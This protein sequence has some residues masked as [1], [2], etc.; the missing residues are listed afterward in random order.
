MFEPRKYVNQTADWGYEDMLG[1]YENGLISEERM[2]E[3]AALCD[4][5]EA[6]HLAKLS[7]KAA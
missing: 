6:E 1:S 7:S 4:E 5:I 2:A 3:F